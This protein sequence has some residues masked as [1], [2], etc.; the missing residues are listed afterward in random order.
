ALNTSSR[1][2]S[3]TR[4]WTISRSPRASMVVSVSVAGMFLLLSLQ[5]LQHFVEAIHLLFPDAAVGVN[6]R[7]EL[8][9]RLRAQAVVPLLGYRVDFDQAGFT[10]D[11]EVLGHLW[12]A[13]LQLDHDP[14]DGLGP[15]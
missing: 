15:L 12:L 8:L 2:A 9:E 6:P 14:S 7:G 11:A 3:K 5:V 13:Q 4:V 10:E 1:G